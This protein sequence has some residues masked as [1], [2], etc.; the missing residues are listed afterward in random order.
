[1]LPLDFPFPEGAGSESFST[2]VR[3]SR[4]D[5]GR[6]T[7]DVR[8]S[9]FEVFALSRHKPLPAS[10]LQRFNELPLRS[11]PERDQRWVIPR[12]NFGVQASMFD[13]RCS[14]LSLPLPSQ[15]GSRVGYPAFR[16]QRFNPFNAPT[17]RPFPAPPAQP[18]N[19][20]LT[21]NPGFCMT[22]V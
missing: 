21:P 6:W 11:P 15:D 13:V 2:K 9:R 22:C 1:M 4:F 3:S 8:G 19:G 16:L 20:L 17:L 12:P 18:S 7:L 10:T 5:V 14:M